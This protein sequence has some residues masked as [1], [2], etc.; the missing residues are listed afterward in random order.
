MDIVDLEI[1]L[2]IVQAQ[3]ISNAASALFLS[4]STIGSRL[5]ALEEEL[6]FSLLVRKKGYKTIQ[7]TEK[8]KSFIPYAEQW[9]H[10]WN[11]SLNL[12]DASEIT[13][14]SFGCSS[15][16]LYFSVGIYQEFQAANPHLQMDVSILE[17]DV[18]YTLV[19]HNKL[20]IAL[21]MHPSLVNGV[22]T[23]ELFKENLVISYSPNYNIVHQSHT[24]INYFPLENQILLI[25]NNGFE[26]WYTQHVPYYSGNILRVNS[27]LVL[28]EFFDTSRSWAI[29]P[30]SVAR[31]L[32][33]QKNISYC[34][35]VENP[36]Q[37]S[38]YF[39]TSESNKEK[40]LTESFCSMLAAYTES[41]IND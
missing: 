18:A 19:Q 28:T 31:A 16:L 39:V 6:G 22:I 15:S 9:L 20:D 14:F 29:V 11:Q 26:E 32:H 10:L 33:S 27:A 4:P 25:W 41:F 38:V 12:K 2:T 36:P 34:Y 35:I 5:K 17:S 23:Q 30:L 37:R 40:P 1:F 8:G 7:L 24:S 13:K 3:S 21:I